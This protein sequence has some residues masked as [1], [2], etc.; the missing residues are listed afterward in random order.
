MTCQ[1]S[2]L[3]ISCILWKTISPLARNDVS[4]AS[5][6]KHGNKWIEERKKWASNGWICAWSM[7]KHLVLHQ[8]R[9]YCLCYKFL[10]LWYRKQR[11]VQMKVSQINQWIKF[12]KIIS[13]T[14]FAFLSKIVITNSV[15]WCGHNVSTDKLKK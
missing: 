1:Q 7:V 14:F 9:C 15:L 10:L 5:I 2:Y 11:S 3:K 8:R 12:T 4:R 13:F 6:L